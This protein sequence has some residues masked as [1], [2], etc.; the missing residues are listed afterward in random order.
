MS[1]FV[2]GLSIYFSIQPWKLFSGLFLLCSS[3]DCASYEV[4]TLKLSCIL[5]REMCVF[6]SLI[7]LFS[8]ILSLTFDFGSPMSFFKKLFHIS[9]HIMYC[10]IF[11][12]ALTSLLCSLLAATVRRSFGSR[13]RRGLRFLT[14]YCS[15]YSVTRTSV[16]PQFG[17]SLSLISLL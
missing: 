11:I 14:S 15:E 17:S 13:G 5:G 3:I 9:F 6:I 2:L 7:W 12:A 16:K 1:I 10:F 8:S 4:Q